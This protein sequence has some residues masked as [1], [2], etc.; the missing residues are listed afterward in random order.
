MNANDMI[1][2]AQKLAGVRSTTRIA[3]D[4]WLL[5]LNQGSNRLLRAFHGE[6]T[7]TSTQTVYQQQEY[8]LPSDCPVGAVQTVQ[9]GTDDAELI[10]WLE[11]RM[12]ELS[13]TWWDTTSTVCDTPTHYYVKNT[14][15]SRKIGL[16][17]VPDTSSLTITIKYLY[18]AAELTSTSQTVILDRDFHMGVV[19]FMAAQGADIVNDERKSDR[20]MGKFL[21]EEDR[22]TGIV[23]D[24]DG[25]FYRVEMVE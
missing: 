11:P 15:T 9:V 5:F 7:D 20:M 10:P 6:K 19:Y 3:S 17:P 23:A 25:G 8:N 14:P 12:S 1:S 24:P 18:E 16:Y 21:E 13:D 4:T 22:L 2:T